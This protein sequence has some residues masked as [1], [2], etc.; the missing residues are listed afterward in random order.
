MQTTGNPSDQKI[1]EFLAVLE[2]EPENREAFGA[3]RALYTENQRW[4]ALLR[5]YDREARRVPDGPSRA[6]M[7]LG[8]GRLFDEQIGNKQQAM[9]HYQLAFRRHHPCLA[10]LKR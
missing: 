3:L 2:T 10:K 4:D 6:E 1:Q 9:K 8:M 5:L 7:Y